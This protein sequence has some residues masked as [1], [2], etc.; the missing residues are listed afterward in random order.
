MSLHQA[1]ATS[2]SKTRTPP[3]DARVAVCIGPEGGF[4]EEEVE[5]LRGACEHGY[6]VTLGPSILRTETAGIVASALTLYELG[7]LQ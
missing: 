7:G 3:E 6:S 4:T 1:I 2:L 5:V